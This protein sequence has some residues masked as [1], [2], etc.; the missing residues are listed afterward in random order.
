[1]KRKINREGLRRA[2]R[3]D[4]VDYSNLTA[5]RSLYKN[6]D[7]IASYDYHDLDLKDDLWNEI[8]PNSGMEAIFKKACSLSSW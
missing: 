5:V 2:L 3:L 8:E 4:P 7:V 1:M 6:W